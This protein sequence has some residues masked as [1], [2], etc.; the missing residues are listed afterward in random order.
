MN[1]K[2]ASA[3]GKMVWD[4][5]IIRRELL[6]LPRVMAFFGFSG[7]NFE[8]KLV[9]QSERGELSSEIKARIAAGQTEYL[10]YIA[11][12]GRRA[13]GDRFGPR[14]LLPVVENGQIC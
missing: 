8:R 3:P 11:R 5:Y 7:W 4:Q 1:P 14:D 13:W 9:S 12:Q 2:Q 6:L 10:G